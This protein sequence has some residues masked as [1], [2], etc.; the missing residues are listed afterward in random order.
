MNNT[1]TW[2]RP[3]KTVT[4]RVRCSEALRSELVRIAIFK[5][6]ELSTVV[7]EACKLHVQQYQR[8]T[9]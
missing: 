5:E 7:R 8:Q 1:P 4:I 2:I 3:R 9:S 6:S